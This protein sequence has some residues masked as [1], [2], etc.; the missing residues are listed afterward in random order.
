MVC[1]KHQHFPLF[2]WKMLWDGDVTLQCSPGQEFM[3]LLSRLFWVSSLGK[4]CV[5]R[6][7]I[8]LWV[9]LFRICPFIHPQGVQG[10]A[11]GE[12]FT[13]AQGSMSVTPPNNPFLSFPC[14]CRDT[15]SLHMIQ[16]RVFHTSLALGQTGVSPLWS[17][18]R[19]VGLLFDAARVH[20][21]PQTSWCH[22]GSDLKLCSCL[23]K[24]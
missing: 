9:F 6:P 14:L 12:K 15:P 13:L 3:I 10:W 5:C 20:L 4:K 7:L 23:G 8:S 1:G 19:V 18:T 22:S 11:L 21:E 16:C 2:F 24:E 17:Q